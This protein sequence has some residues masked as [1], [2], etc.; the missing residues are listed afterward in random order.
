[1]AN[2]KRGKDPGTLPAIIKKA[3][4]LQDISII[5]FA[6]GENWLGLSFKERPAQEVILR[7]MYGLPLDE[8]QLKIFKILTKGKIKYKPGIIRFE[9]IAC[10]GARSGKSFLVSIVALYEAT[11]DQW[12]KFVSKRESPYIV[13]IA[14]RQKQ[15][16]AIIGANC[17][18]MLENSP[19]LKNMIKESF[20]T[21]L[22]LTNGVKILSLPCN[23]TAGRGLPIAILIFDEI[24]FYR[25]EG[26]KADS[27]IFDSLRPRQAQFPD[28]KMLMISTAGSKQGLFF[29]FFNEGFKIQDRL[30]IQGETKFLNPLIPVKFLEKEK[31]RDIDNYLREFKGIFSEKLEAFFSWELMQKPFVL[32]GDLPYN[33]EYIYYLA[34]DQSGLSGRDRFALAISHKEG[35]SVIVD[36]VRSWQTKDLDIILD[37]IKTLAGTFCISEAIIDRYSKGYVEASFKKISLEVKIRPSLADVYVNLKSKMIQDKLKLPDRPDLRAG[38]RNTIAIYN[39]SNQLTIIH[40]RGPE[41]HSDSLDA[42]ASAVFEAS[43]EEGLPYFYTLPGDE[44]ESEGWVEVER[45]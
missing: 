33:S 29:N 23:S 13:I 27:L 22:T 34:L 28:C 21:E 18:R 40:E 38:L 25:L 32:A 45:E 10:L 37:E 30:T 26:V 36:I 6:T 14:T 11:R 42:C 16:E 7:A 24:A 19:V 3:K 2:L 17:A 41:G 9:M 1:M 5:E 44:E 4:K 8:E 15:A 39:K 12:K 35:D 20:K 31:A 43:Q